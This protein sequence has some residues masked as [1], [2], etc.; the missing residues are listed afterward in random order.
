[1]SPSNIRLVSA[2]EHFSLS[3]DLHRQIAHLP[4]GAKVR[5]A[6]GP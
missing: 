6:V 4:D 3:G 1:L 5:I 2:L